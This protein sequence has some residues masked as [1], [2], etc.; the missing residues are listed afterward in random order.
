M[1]ELVRLVVSGLRNCKRQY[2][3]IEEKTDHKRFRYIEK[4]IT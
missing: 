2:R 1:Q 3:F 4:F